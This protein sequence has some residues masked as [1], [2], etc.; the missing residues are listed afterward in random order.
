MNN[1]EYLVNVYIMTEK[2]NVPDYMNNII[3]SEK[4]NNKFRY[5]FFLQNDIFA[6]LKD[7]ESIFEKYVEFMKKMDIPFVMFPY[8][9]HINSV[10]PATNCIPNPNLKLI[11]NDNKVD[12]LN[13][14]AYGFLG[15]DLEKFNQIGFRFKS[16][17]PIM[18]YLQNMLEEFYQKGITLSNCCYMD[19][20]ESWKYFKTH[21]PEGFHQN[22]DKFNAEKK[23]YYE[24]E[25][26]YRNMNEFVN[27]FKEKYCNKK[28]DIQSVSL[29]NNTDIPVLTM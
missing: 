19:M 15:I 5:L 18:F 20:E 22:I 3:E 10:L 24:K 16:E 2:L 8:Y 23:K 12:I 4:K 14:P 1:K 11:Y 25:F 27:A 6:N 21:T 13:A 17:F 28:K 29:I 26:K 9:I 7:K